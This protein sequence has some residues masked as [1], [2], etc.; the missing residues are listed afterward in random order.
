MKTEQLKFLEKK[1]NDDYLKKL[2]LDLVLSDSED[3]VIKVLDKAGYWH[4][5]KC[6]IHYGLTENNFA[7]IG[8][9]Q[10]LPESAL[11][12][13]IINSVD[14][15]LMLECLLRNIDPESKNA[16]N[17]IYDAL[18][19]FL[20]I[21]EGKLSNLTAN[22]RTIFAEK[23]CLVAS[24]SKSNPC[25][26]IIDKGEGQTAKRMPDTFLSIGGSNKLR[27]P[28]VQGKFNMGG[29]GVF[30]F[31]GK[32]NLQLIVSRRN[33]QI[34]NNEEDET[35]NKWGFTIVRR[36]DPSYGVR[37]SIYK[38]LAPD[39]KILNFECESLPLIPS[40]YPISYGQDLMWGTFIKLYEYQMPG[41][42]KTNILF[43]LYNR[44]SLLMPSI[45]LPV[46]LYER[47]K[48]YSGH[49]FESTL[50]GLSVRL[51]E[52]K[53]E[54]LEEGFPTSITL[55]LNGQK[56][57][58]SIFAFKKGSAEKYIRDE[59]II[60]ILN[61]QTHGHI[62]KYF[63]SRESVGMSYLRDSLLVII[64]CSSFEGR[65][66]EDLFMNSRDRLRSG[67]FQNE[68][69]KN[70]AEILRNHEGLKA[71]RERR[72]REEIEDKLKDSEPLVNVLSDILKKSPALSKLFIEGVRLKNP[73]KVLGK[74]AEDIYIGKRFP[75]SFKI[76]KKY[77]QNNPKICALNRRFRIQY[78]TDA[79]N[80]YFDREVDPGVFILKANGNEVHN[81]SMNYSMNL[82]NGTATL[83]V[84]L[85]LNKKI[86]DT[87]HFVS[88][89]SDCSRIQPFIED[90]YVLVGP[91][92]KKSNGGKGERKKPPSDKPGDD[93]I[94]TSNLDLPN[95]IE[96]RRD[97][98]SN[99]SFNNESVLDVKDTGEGGYD[100][101]INMDNI[102]LLTEL[103][104]N[105]IDEK[106]LI[107][108]YKFGMVLIGIAILK[109][110][111][112]ELEKNNDDNKEETDVYNKIREITKEISPVLL[113]MINYLGNL[114]LD[115]I[116][117]N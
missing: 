82:W 77:D 50:S 19:N 33:P 83:N 2:C 51:E 107:A 55:S 84:E 70:L 22:E 41:G 5:E 39:R 26:S 64:D 29:T 94:D 61:G 65:T 44:L 58:A 113:P 73:L 97:K 11:V 75:I 69:E 43:D 66:R 115:D 106:I 68:I 105:S 114:K 99:F 98:W 14:A 32:K 28:F 27:I 21:P 108:K 3:E 88:E 102:H 112:I 37:S 53:R 36:E 23:I 7:T 92:E 104:T 95:I 117:K 103:K 81:Y 67:E 24:G 8:N 20:K 71:L 46:R 6:W 13:K 56:M 30:Q 15:V 63:F 79:N 48:G 101:F 18:Y 74:K 34:S 57:R 76:L 110:K 62:S 72:R 100:F 93:S 25:Y 109:N 85:P 49:S 17:S 38:Y 78:Q 1:T 91:E 35:K 47:R 12:E 40:T 111:S 45:A 60:F 96:I 42:L 54:N 116:E 59:G 80:D 31:C 89:I 90:F 9:Q 86:G 10:S 4:D 87:F 52:D 16:P